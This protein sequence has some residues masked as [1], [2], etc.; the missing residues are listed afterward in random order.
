MAHHRTPAVSGINE[1]TSAHGSALAA[2]HDRTA[3][4]GIIGMGY[5]GLPLALTAAGAGFSVLGFDI[6]GPRVDK[7]N[8]G[9]SNIKHIPSAAITDAR[10]N[11]RFEATADF[12]RLGEPDAILICVPT[13]L[14]RHREPD[15]SFVV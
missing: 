2:F 11:G 14:T 4:I 8:R 1:H 13:P 7:L 12:D 6:D 5:V 9:E 10:R 15:L 3:T